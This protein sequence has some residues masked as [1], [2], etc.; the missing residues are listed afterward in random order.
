M[1]LGRFVEKALVMET[2]F[3]LSNF[4]QNFNFRGGGGGGGKYKS[5]QNVNVNKN[6]EQKNN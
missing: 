1:K 6:L 2:E 4:E 3:F 5:L